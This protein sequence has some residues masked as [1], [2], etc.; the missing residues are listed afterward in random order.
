MIVVMKL[1]ALNSEIEAVCQRATELGLTPHLC[2]QVQ[3]ILISLSGSTEGLSPEDISS[4]PGIERVVSV[5]PP[6][7]KLASRQNRFDKTTIKI[8]D[9]V[10]V[11]QGLTIIAGPCSVESHAQILE[12]AKQIKTYGAHML[13]GGVFKPRSLPYRFRGIG[14]IGLDYLS[15]AGE[16]TGL[17][18]VTEVMTPHMVEKVVQK[19]DVLQIG[20]RNMT[21]TDLLLEV[22]QTDKPVLLKRGMC[23]TIKELLMAAEYILAAGNPNVILC[24]RGIRTFETHTR[25]TLDLNA[26]PSLKN[27]THLPVFVDPSHGTGRSELVLPMARAAVACGADGLL[28]EVHPNPNYSITDAQQAISPQMFAQLVHETQAIFSLLHPQPSLSIK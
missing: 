11:G 8:S 28:V 26:V 2:D 10:V 12:T 3:Q 19:A 21:N 27:L 17:P 14:E 24:E 23:A 9:K 25:N 20:T 6:P 16:A 1:G 18:I 5:G 13:R 4:L 7:Y 15:E 22:G